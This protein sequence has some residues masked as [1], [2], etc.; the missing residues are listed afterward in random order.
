M[1]SPARQAAFAILF[2][3][4]TKS[5][6]ATEL[7][8]SPLTERLSER[9]AALCTELVLGTLRHQGTF[10]FI[11]EQRTQG[12]FKGFDPAVKI[13]L[14]MGLYQMRH[15]SRV[16]ARAAVSESVELIKQA[17]KTSAAGLVNAVLRRSAGAELESLRPPAMDEVDWE[18][19]RTSHPRWM[20]ERWASRWGLPAAAA[21]AHANNEPPQ[22]CFRRGVSSRTIDDLVEELRS[23]GAHVMPGSILKSCYTVT[24]I[25][26]GKTELVRRGELVIQDEA[27]QLVPHLLD[28]LPGQRVLDLCAAPGNKTGMLASWVGERG[29]VV[30]CDVHLHRLRQFSNPGY[31]VSPV[32]SLVALDGAQDLPFPAVFDR[33]LVDAPCSGTGT[34]R[35]HPEI[36]WRLRPDDITSLAMLQFRMLEKA[37][38]VLR[39]GGKLVYSTCSLEREENQEVVDRFLQAHAQFRFFP[40]RQD[41]ARIQPYLQPAA[42]S[43]LDVECLETSPAHH[44]TDGFFAAILA[45]S[46]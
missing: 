1:P 46:E 32:A 22:T 33:A 14:R 23:S 45:R 2:R 7:L 4:E 15:L 8:H 5:S 31:N 18:A 25:N 12:R 19:I 24:G 35:R 44:S 43:I 34:L 41:A 26:P 13:A 29:R 38:A 36:K 27:S 40:L 3:V 10:D 37:A 6:Y 39:P 20:L 16:P 42:S 9:D 30:A 11:A 28:V 21:L 17:G